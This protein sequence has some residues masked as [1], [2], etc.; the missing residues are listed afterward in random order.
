MSDTAH[1]ALL[2]RRPRT[3]LRVVA[4]TALRRA[5]IAPKQ[6]GQYSSHFSAAGSEQPRALQ[7]GRALAP[8][9]IVFGLAQDVTTT[10][11]SSAVGSE[12]TT[13]GR[14]GRVGHPRQRSP[15]GHKPCGTGGGSRTAGYPDCVG[16][17][18]TTC[19]VSF[20]VPLDDVDGLVVVA[21]S[22]TRVDRSDPS[23]VLVSPADLLETKLRHDADSNERCG[24]L[25]R[26]WLQRR[27]LPS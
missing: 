4:L 13:P 16:S 26:Y 27:S 20:L 14:V 17:R 21:H 1:P 24:L 6:C 25:R 9:R 2:I 11:P 8:V 10:P 19:D 12:G 23:A 5:R 3:S 15:S 18:S 7:V 22:R